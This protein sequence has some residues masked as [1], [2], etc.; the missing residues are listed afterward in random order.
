M[1]PINIPVT[2]ILQRLKALSVATLCA[3]AL[4]LPAQGQTPATLSL[5]TVFYG[6][7]AEFFNPFRAGET[8]LGAWQR[9]NFDIQISDKAALRLG[10]Y[11]LERDGSERRSELARPVVALI[12]GTKRHRFIMGTLETGDRAAGMGPDRTTPHGV[13]PPLAI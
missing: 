1:R 5:D 10:L 3:C 11:A 6:D 4:A 8:I 9:V 12:M 7:N 13:L 2:D